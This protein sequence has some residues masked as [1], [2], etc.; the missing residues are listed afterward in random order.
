MRWPHT[1]SQRPYRMQNS[2][3]DA[4]QTWTIQNLI[5]WAAAYLKKHH[6]DSPRLTAELLLSTALGSSRLDLYL[7]YAKPLEDAELQEFKQLLLR[8]ARREPLAYITGV[9]E[10]W[11]L[12]LRVTPAVL[13]PR[14][15]TE[16]LVEEALAILRRHGQD[17][18]GR[19]L[20]LG[21]GSGAIVI[22]LATGQPQH[23]YT[24][25]DVS[26]EAIQLA[27]ENA[28]RLDVD[29]RIDFICADWFD[30][31]AQGEGGQRFDLIV[32]NPP[33]IPSGDLQH[34]APEIFEHEP[35]L[36]LDGTEDGLAC[37]RHIIES[38]P[39]FLKSGGRLLIEIGHDQSV[40]VREMA[41]SAG[42][43][44]ETDFRKD[45]AGH[46][47]VAVLAKK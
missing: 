19:V 47:R 40:D 16:C 29:N 1:I 7:N 18:S 11:S 20:D 2:A 31:V 3:A 4:H 34:L 46:R 23:R 45:M 37:V 36:A 35:H 5:R 10:F 17:G 26:P 43:Y 30:A 33:Y 22:A 25:T 21:T 27:I 32:T 6:V 12:E 42:V 38:A 15:E 44:D 41:K 13:I 39:S 14:P 24:A 28:R 8:R 9:K